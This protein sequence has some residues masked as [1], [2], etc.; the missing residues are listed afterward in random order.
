[1]FLRRGDRTSGGVI[2][3][4]SQSGWR[5]KKSYCGNIG[6]TSIAAPLGAAKRGKRSME[7]ES[8]GQVQNDWGGM[9]GGRGPSALRVNYRENKNEN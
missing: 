8:R 5:E 7:E 1:M 6:I 9:G 4:M 2:C 3:R